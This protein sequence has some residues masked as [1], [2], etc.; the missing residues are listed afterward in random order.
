MKLSVKHMS[1]NTVYVH[2]NTHSGQ[3][4][5]SASL[6]GCYCEFY[7]FISHHNS[8]VARPIADC[9]LLKIQYNNT[10]VANFDTEPWG[11]RYIVLIGYVD[12]MKE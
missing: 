4:D 1:E 3:V 9:I 8:S 10:I 5:G 6:G 12:P 7:I 2:E 11:N